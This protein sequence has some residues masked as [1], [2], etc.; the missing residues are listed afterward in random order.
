MIRSGLLKSSIA[1]PSFKNSG[2][3]AIFTVRLFFNFF[4]FFVN[5]SNSTSDVPTG[6]VDF[7]I[8]IL[9]VVI[10]SAMLLHAFLIL[11]K[12]AKPS[13]CDG[14]STAKNITSE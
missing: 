10:C 5:I 14:V 11:V 8:I 12:S 1:D 2:F 7:S 6:T 4:N 13:S 3:E 9:L